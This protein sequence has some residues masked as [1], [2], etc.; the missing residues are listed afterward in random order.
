MICIAND[1]IH[2]KIHIKQLPMRYDSPVTKRCNPISIRFN[3]MQYDA[4]EI[5]FNQRWVEY[6][7]TV[8]K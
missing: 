5:T 3:T 7:K 1:T 4:M 2:L 8:L 6:P